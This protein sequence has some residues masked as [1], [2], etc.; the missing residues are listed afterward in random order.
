VV[1]G[2]QLREA[3]RRY[4]AGISVVSVDLAGERLAV[5]MG[6]LV[7]LSLDPPLVGISVGKQ[8]ALHEL[9]RAA[10]AFGVSLLTAEQERLAS[11]FARGL[12]PIALWDGVAL[13]AEAPPLLEGC[14]GWLRCRVR[15]ACDAGDHT[16]FV[17][18]VETVELGADAEALVYVR[19]AYRPA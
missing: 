15:A 9:L 2:E 19:A 4:P 7:S 12:P 14:L 18:E 5:T 17:A 13:R 3:M 16:F 6:S 1:T 10:G 11:R 8:N